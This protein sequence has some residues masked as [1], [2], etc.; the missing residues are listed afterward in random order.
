MVDSF[1]IFHEIQQMGLAFVIDVTFVTHVNP[2]VDGNF[3]NQ[4]QGYEYPRFPWNHGYV[5]IY[6]IYHYVIT[7]ID[8]KILVL[9]LVHMHYTS[10][11]TIKKKVMVTI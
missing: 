9:N 2:Y 4:N 7:I 8:G 3:H 5:H 6:Y 10:I 11:I 1:F